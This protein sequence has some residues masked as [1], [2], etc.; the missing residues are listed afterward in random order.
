MTFRKFE[1]HLY[2]KLRDPEYA[3]MYMETAME[4]GGVDDFLQALQEVIKAQEGG[5]RRAAEEIGHGRES[6]YKSIS[7]R[8]N[9]GIKTVSNLLETLG[10]KIT[11]TPRETPPSTTH[12]P[13]DNLAH[14]R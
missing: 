1:E 6:L 8:G 4:M 14:A 7:K 11:V 2:E 5:M 9:P 3:A 12:L 10:L 13:N